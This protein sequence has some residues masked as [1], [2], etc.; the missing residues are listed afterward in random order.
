MPTI[1]WSFCRG[2]VEPVVWLDVLA[3]ES[4]WALTDG[5]IGRGGEGSLH[6]D[7]YARVGAFIRSERRLWY[8]HLNLKGGVPVFTDGRHRFAWLRDR[9]AKAVPFTT[10]QDEASDLARRFGTTARQTTFD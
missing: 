3:L 4:A 6:G 2:Y 1:T 9:G 10:S 7:R 8:L 5:Y